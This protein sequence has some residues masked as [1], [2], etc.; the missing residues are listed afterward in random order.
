MHGDPMSAAIG[1]TIL[2]M[3]LSSEPWNSLCITFH[4]SPELHSVDP[5][6]TFLEKLKSLKEMSWGGTTNLNK[7]FDLILSKGSEQRLTN[8]QM[9]K[10]LIIFTDMEF[11]S[12]FPGTSMTN[13]EAAKLQ[14]ESKGYKLPAIVFWN[15]R[16]NNSLKST[17]VSYNE[18]GAALMAGYSGQQ[19]ALILKT[20]DFEKMSAYSLMRSAIDHKRYAG[21]KVID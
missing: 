19:L 11:N 5:N 4:E 3:S 10:L 7:V 9:P 14:F 13:F 6:E 1:L 12:A 20:E 15:L 18:F 21:L 2:V 17:P 16:G 8:E